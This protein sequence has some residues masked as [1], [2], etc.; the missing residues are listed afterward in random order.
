[1]HSTWN[2]MTIELQFMLLPVFFFLL[3]SISLYP[4][5]CVKFT[6]FLFALNKTWSNVLGIAEQP[7][8]QI[9][10]LR[11]LYKYCV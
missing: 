10:Y 3:S 5:N 2:K 6:Q 4:D 7:F 9:Y 11:T 1:M 8:Q